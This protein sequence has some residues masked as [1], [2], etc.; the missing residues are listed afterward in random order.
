MEGEDAVLG[1]LFSEPKWS[2]ANL[3]AGYLPSNHLCE[4]KLKHPKVK[5]NTTHVDWCAS[6]DTK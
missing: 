6:M 2:F 3:A 4:N 5:G 1:K